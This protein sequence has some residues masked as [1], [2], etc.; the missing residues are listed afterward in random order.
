VWLVISC[1]HVRVSGVSL[2]VERLVVQVKKVL[3]GTAAFC[4]QVD[5]IIDE[6]ILAKNKGEA[7]V[8][9]CLSA[10]VEKNVSRAAHTHTHTRTCLLLHSISMHGLTRR[11][12]LARGH[13]CG[14]VQMTRKQMYSHLV[15]MVAAGHDT[16][17][18]CC[19]YC[20]Y[21]LAK[22]PEVSA[23][24]CKHHD[25][26]MY[27]HST[28]LQ[29][30][31]HGL[32]LVAANAAYPLA[33]HQVQQ[34]LK[35]EVKRVLGN[36]TELTGADY[37]QLTYARNCFQETLRLYSVVPHVTRLCTEETVSQL[38]LGSHV[39]LLSPLGEL[40]CMLARDR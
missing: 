38:L 2:S 31:S 20:I 19:C 26:C 1:L 10:M 30:A 6:R 39:H 33:P 16:T 21:L 17:S 4:H 12:W 35:K 36:R 25:T 14:C 34:K 9:D 24:T 29:G 40:S 11:C 13:G 28:T 18:Y 23:H 8:D 7:L 37:D 3:E 5:P 15:T 27:T 22:N 32:E